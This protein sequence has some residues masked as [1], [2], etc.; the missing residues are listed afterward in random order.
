MVV[1]D[2]PTNRT[3]LARQVKRSG[4]VVHTAV[5]GQDGLKVFSSQHGNGRGVGLVI[6]DMTMPHLNGD[7][8]V[9]EMVSMCAQR[10]WHVPIF[11]VV[12]GN[13]L[14]DDQEAMRTAGA[15]VV[16]SKPARLAGK[17]ALRSRCWRQ[18]S[19]E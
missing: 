7:G 12:S 13:V 5:D 4:Y 6:T 15:H 16:L 2:A 19:T 11:V 8:M 3:L 1:D 17:G 14:E 18:D 9:R 10:G